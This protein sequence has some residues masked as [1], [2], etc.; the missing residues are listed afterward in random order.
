MSCRWNVAMID[1]HDRF[2]RIVVPDVSC[3]C[4]VMM[5]SCEEWLNRT[6]FFHGAPLVYL[7]LMFSCFLLVYPRIDIFSCLLCVALGSS[8][9]L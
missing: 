5:F 2:I 7:L 9:C 4:N 1:G 6:E 3:V 8:I